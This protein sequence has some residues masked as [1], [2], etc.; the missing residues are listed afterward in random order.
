MS[1]N[2]AALPV[3]CGLSEVHCGTLAWYKRCLSHGIDDLIYLQMPVWPF[4]W[5]RWPTMLWLQTCLIDS[6]L[7]SDL[8]K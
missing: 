8:Q 7:E 4:Q 6:T 5:T 3:Q 2:R 1:V